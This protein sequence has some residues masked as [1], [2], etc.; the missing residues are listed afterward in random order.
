MEMSAENFSQLVNI[1]LMEQDLNAKTAARS[2][3]P[4]PLGN[5]ATGRGPQD[6]TMIYNTWINNRKKQKQK[7]YV[8]AS[9]YVRMARNRWTADW[10]TVHTGIAVKAPP[11][12]SVQ[13]VLR[14]FGSGLKLK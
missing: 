12:V 3:T 1:L 9:L 5:T 4:R 6:A 8:L 7:E 2:Q 11:S 13:N 10:L 14:T